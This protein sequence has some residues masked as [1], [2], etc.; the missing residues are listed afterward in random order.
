MS[1]LAAVSIQGRPNQNQVSLSTS[2][3]PGLDRPKLVP[4]DQES[5][6]LNILPRLQHQL[7]SR[8]PEA[9]T[10]ATVSGSG[11]T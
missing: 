10:A 5:N 1:A 7:H 11:D 6:L 3:I 2:S 4:K 8:P 9:K